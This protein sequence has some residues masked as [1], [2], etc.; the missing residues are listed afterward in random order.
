MSLT[1]TDLEKIREI[2]REEVAQYHNPPFD[3]K[4]KMAQRCFVCQKSWNEIGICANTACP[5]KVEITCSN[6]TGEA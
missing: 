6:N 5:N 1:K 2:V 4:I 3:G